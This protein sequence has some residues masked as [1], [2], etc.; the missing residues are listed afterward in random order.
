MVKAAQQ[1]VGVIGSGL[2]GLAAACVLAARGQKVVVFEK[3]AWIG[4]KAAELTGKGYRFD[5]GPTIL[6]M[7]KVL[8]RSF[9]E[10][11]KQAEDYL[12]L[13][14]LDPQGRCFF[15]DGT[16]MDLVEDKERMAAA[17]EKRRAGSG[18]GYKKFMAWAEELH[19]IS[20]RWFF[21]KSVGGIKDAI[22]PAAAL[23]PSTLKDLLAIRMGKS[24]AG[25]VRSFVT[26]DKSAQ[27]LDHY[28]QYVGS[29]PYDSPAV[30]CS[31]AS[32]QTNEGVWYPIGGTRA[33]PVALEKLGRELG[34]EFRV[35]TEIAKIVVENGAVAG[36]VTR[37]G[38]QVALGALVSN[39]DAVRTHTELVGG[40]IGAAFE[41]KRYEPACSGVVLYLGLKKAYEHLAHHDFVFSR[42][43]EEEFEHIYHK[44]AP[45][46]DPT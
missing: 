15:A 9:A 17:I 21:W 40:E 3:N 11:G 4:G 35:E 13:V 34:V 8:T 36:V 39:M 10:A 24:V 37:K 23:K 26:D 44:G 2:G 25:S 16:T 19:E 12:K 46:P 45:A 18:E 33:V 43:P 31:I 6:T 29:S 41:K 5:I 7:P 32:M 27:M 38:E 22:P 20:E 1:T 30:L 42:D 28:T 14:R